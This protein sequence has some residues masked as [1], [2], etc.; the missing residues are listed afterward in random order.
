[1]EIGWKEVGSV[2]CDLCSCKENEACY[3][4]LKDEHVFRLGEGMGYLAKF[5]TGC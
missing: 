1:M 2:Q 3:G 5:P 4:S